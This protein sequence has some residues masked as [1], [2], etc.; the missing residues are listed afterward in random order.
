MKYVMFNL[1]TRKEF[2]TKEA[3]S[4]AQAKEAYHLQK[5][6]EGFRGFFV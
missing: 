6:P 3:G 5:T 1:E 4:I 2:V